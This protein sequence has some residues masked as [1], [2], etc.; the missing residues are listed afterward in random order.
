MLNI[1]L[2]REKLRLMSQMIA[3]FQAMLPDELPSP[4]RLVVVKNGDYDVGNNLPYMEKPS[5]VREGFAY[6][7]PDNHNGTHS[8]FP[9]T[10][11]GIVDSSKTKTALSGKTIQPGNGYSGENLV[12][13]P[14]IEEIKEMLIELDLKGSLRERPSGL[15]EFRSAK[16]G[17][18]YGRTKE[19]LK[20]KLAKKLQELHDHAKSAKTQKPMAP[21]LSE[22]F[23]TVYLPYKK[24]T[25]RAKNTIGGYLSHMKFIIERGFDKRL[26][27]YTSEEIEEF[28]FS[29]PE[30][31][32]R[33]I[34]QGFLNNIFKR[35]LAKSVVKVNPCAALEKME[36]G[37]EEGTAFDFLELKKFFE[38]A[39]TLSK[40]KK[41]YLLF[42]FLT[43]CRRNEALAVQERDVDFERKILHVHG[44]KTEGSDRYIPLF[45]LVEKLLRGL[46][47]KQGLY[48]P[49]S[50]HVAQDSI[51][52]CTQDHTLHD[53]RHTLGTIQI[54]VEKID[55]KTVSLW[56][57]H[58]NIETTLRIYTHPEQLD[59]ATFIRGDMTEPEK[60]ATLRTQYADILRQ[61]ADI[62]E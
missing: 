42:L 9:R 35:A 24:S 20:R 1:E 32:K 2:M 43:G 19:E 33:Q 48:F 10:L 53:L 47:P 45:P 46:E 39:A 58:S 50:E 49:F 41:A 28:L 57:G 29:I 37:G 31:R 30:T 36:H 3:E 16:F 12:S 5:R 21:L 22:F 15:L 44:T 61:V 13:K 14:L 26:P 11:A 54:C 40:Q 52:K 23:E 51:K 60:L 62:I 56:L 8:P 25:N 7:S 6:P 38:Q 4:P 18:V 55:V 59:R 34:I 17:S 27:K